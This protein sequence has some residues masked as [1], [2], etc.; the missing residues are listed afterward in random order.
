MGI[1]KISHSTRRRDVLSRDKEGRCRIAVKVRLWTKSLDKDHPVLMDGY[2][3]RIGEA[4][5]GPPDLYLLY[6]DC[7]TIPTCDFETRKYFI[8]FLIL[9]LNGMSSV[10]CSSLSLFSVPESRLVNNHCA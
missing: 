8:T 3:A 1:Y 2:H 7:F 4:S 9:Y 6:C 10:G 5:E